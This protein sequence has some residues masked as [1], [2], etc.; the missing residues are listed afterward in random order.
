MYVYVKVSGPLEPES[1]TGVN[2]PVLVL[3]KSSQYS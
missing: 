1:Q 2:C 3:W